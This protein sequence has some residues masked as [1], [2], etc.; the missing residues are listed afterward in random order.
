MYLI[1]FDFQGEYPAEFDRNYISTVSYLADEYLIHESK[2]NLFAKI[3]FMK[4]HPMMNKQLLNAAI[5]RTILLRSDF[6]NDILN[7][8]EVIIQS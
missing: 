8:I 7:P 3:C 4:P 6:S 2:E 1:L 5:I